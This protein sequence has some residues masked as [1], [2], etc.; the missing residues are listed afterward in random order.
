M[1][2]MVGNHN[3]VIM[4]YNPPPLAYGCPHPWSGFFQVTVDNGNK[5]RVF[6]I[7]QQ[8]AFIPTMRGNHHPFWSQT[9]EPE[10]LP[11]NMLTECFRMIGILYP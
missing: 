3:L 8:G 7:D 1:H 6:V 4:Q 10:Y 11:T 2:L 5:Q 9:K